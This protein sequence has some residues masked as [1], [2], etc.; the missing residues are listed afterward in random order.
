MPFVLRVDKPVL[1]AIHTGFERARTGKT[2]SKIE[3]V[4]R[5]YFPHVQRNVFFTDTGDGEVLVHVTGPE[6][7][8]DARGH[9]HLIAVRDQSIPA[10]EQ[11]LHLAAWLF[12]LFQN[13]FLYLGEVREMFI[14]HSSPLPQI[15]ILN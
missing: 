9:H 14:L 8:A 11:D 6:L 3:S 2:D 1:G 7:D 15:C 12:G 4:S 5:V 13:P 10:H